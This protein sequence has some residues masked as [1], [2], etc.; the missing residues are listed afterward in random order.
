MMEIF[1]VDKQPYRLLDLQSDSARILFD[2]GS[3]IVLQNLLHDLV[4]TDIRPNSQ[5]LIAYHE[6]ISK[7]ILSDNYHDP[8]QPP[9]TLPNII[10]DIGQLIQGKDTLLA[11]TGETWFV[12]QHIKLP[13]GA[14][15]HAQVAYALL[16]W[17]LPAA[18]GS[19]VALPI[20]V[21]YEVWHGQ[22]IQMKIFRERQIADSWR[23]A[24]PDS[25]VGLLTT[26]DG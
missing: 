11:D 15:C 21:L 6:R 19:Q 23:E 13:P 9:V 25:G 16:G 3:P 4:E 22:E 18:L 20:G 7:I 26:R 5:S 10:D 14:A 1:D 8:G 2:D 24:D 12:S 17:A